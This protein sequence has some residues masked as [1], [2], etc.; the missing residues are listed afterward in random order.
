VVHRAVPRRRLIPRLA[1]GPGDRLFWGE[2]RYMSG[3]EKPH[4]ALLQLLTRLTD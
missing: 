2:E 3:I 4:S 1:G